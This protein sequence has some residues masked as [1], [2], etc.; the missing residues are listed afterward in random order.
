MLCLVQLVAFLQLDTMKSETSLLH[1]SQRFAIVSLLNHT[2]SH[3]LV[4]LRSANIDDNSRLDIAA[5]GFWGS[6]FDVQVFNPC[7]RSNRQASLL[8]T[9]RRH[10]QEKKRQYDRRIR[11]VEHSTFTLLVLSTTGGAATTFYKRLA[12]MLS[13]KRDVPYSKMIGWIRCRMSFRASVMSIRGTRSSATRGALHEPI[14][15]QATEGQ[16]QVV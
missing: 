9:Y 3:S 2:C 7:A 15:L 4:R 16:L 12:A 10:E 6:R 5:C 1:F 11:E 14:E 8:A 13:E